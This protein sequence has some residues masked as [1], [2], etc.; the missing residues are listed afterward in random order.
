MWS[1]DLQNKLRQEQ[2]VSIN[3]D[4]VNILSKVSF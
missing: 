4:D 1:L 2:P 3:V